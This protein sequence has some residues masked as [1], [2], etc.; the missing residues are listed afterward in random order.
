MPTI[1]IK[2]IKMN[3]ENYYQY[4]L[5]NYRMNISKKLYRINDT[6]RKV[7]LILKGVF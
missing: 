4:N 6:I 1:I 5:G 2:K 7:E 3:L